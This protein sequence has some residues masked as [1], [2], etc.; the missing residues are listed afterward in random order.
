MGRLQR[1][2]RDRSGEPRDCVSC[3]AQPVK[4]ANERPR[5]IIQGMALGCQQIVDVRWLMGIRGMC[6]G[7]PSLEYLF[8]GARHRPESHAV[9]S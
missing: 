9:V 8:R 7:Q 4:A 1:E 5:P 6:N 3:V 2:N